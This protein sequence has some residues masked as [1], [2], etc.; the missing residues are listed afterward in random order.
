MRVDRCLH[1]AFVRST[2]A[3]ASFEIRV[4]DGTRAFTAADLDCSGSADV[5]LLLPEMRVRPL[6]PLARNEA[7]AV[8][9][10]LAF[11]VAASPALAHDAVERIEVAY[12]ELDKEDGAPEWSHLW[13]SGDV[14]AAFAAAAHIVRVRV[15][16]S[17]VAAMPLEPRSTLAAWDA[18][19][20]QLTVWLQTQS[21]HRARDDLAR[22]LG[23]APACVRVVAPDVGGAFGS[24][25][26][27]Y[28]EDVC[29]AWAARHFAT[30]VRWTGS[31]QEEMLSG[32]HGR[33]AALAGE[34]ALDA[35]GSMLALRAQVDFPLGHWTPYSAAVPG[36][37][38]ARILPG[39]YRVHAVEIALK[40]NADNKAPIGIYRGAGRP[41]A[42]MLMERLMDNAARAVGV[43][44]VAF[45]RANLV[46]ASSMPHRTPTGE[47]VDSGDYSR[48]LERALRRAGYDGMRKQ[49]KSRR[50]AGEL[51]G[52]GVA[53]YIE[54]C[55]QGHE[56][57]QVRLTADGHI[58]ATTGSTSQ[59]QGRETAFAQ[60]VAH[61]LS[62]EPSSVTVVH[63][64]TAQI[65]HGVGAL[66]SR[67]TAIGGSAVLRAAEALRDAGAAV[68]RRTMHADAVALCNGAF[69][70]EGC[71]ERS[72]TWR[73]VGEVSNGLECAAEFD[74]LETWGGGACIA[75]VSV[76]RET[77][78]VRI[79]SLTHVDDSGTA[80]NPLLVEGQLHGGIAQGVGEALQERVV[81]DAQGQLLSGSLMDYAVP[82][83]ADVPSVRLDVAP[84]PTQNNLLGAKGVGE[85]GCIGTPAAIVNAVI[86]ALA[87][88]GVHH[89]D[90]PLTAEKLWQAMQRCRPET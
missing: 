60:I 36:R 70:I 62:V 61:A 65:P 81:Y 77:G 2:H 64:D 25:A 34:L 9:Q 82:R 15:E 79:E 7:R 85:A 13:R 10:G 49:Q 51:I 74:S 14:D 55:G 54:P 32:T 72:E 45:R 17:R 42:A 22:I 33:G 71:P 3:R 80:I 44:P 53:L 28:P 56:S 86:D 66:A 19:S 48:T 78:T 75:V 89:V 26:S 84:C 46:P 24:R 73:R 63:G 43:D 29:V 76:D 18:A 1:L 41:E 12:G 83:A 58:I 50:V 88:M 21:P 20:C 68:A 47:M 5:N 38:A 39:P 69:V 16:H 40:A 27:I 30:A 59:G 57:A 6:E 31:R 11:V 52:I 8:G 90:M 67:S 37:N 87:P 35:N 23:L 4:P